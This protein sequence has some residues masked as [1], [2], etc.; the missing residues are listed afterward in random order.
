MD[1]NKLM[2]IKAKLIEPATTVSDEAKTNE[3][4]D[5]GKIID[6]N[7]SYDNYESRFAEL[8]ESYLHLPKEFKKAILALKDL[9]NT[10]YEFGLSVLLGMANTCCQHLYD[11][12]SYK[13]GIRPISLYIMVLLGTAGSKSTIYSEIRGPFVDYCKSKMDTLK[14]EDARYA[15]EMKVYKKLVQQYEKDVEAGL[16]PKYP[17]KPSPAETADYI[18]TKFTVNGLID[19][20]SSQPFASIITAEAGE[21]FSSHAFQGNK[22]DATRATEMTT[23]LTK[24]WDGDMISRVIK[25]ERV[26]VGNR[27]VNSLLMVQEGVI[28]DV[29][30]NKIFQEQGFTHRILI[31]QIHPF[32]KPDMSFDP[33]IIKKEQLARYGLKEYLDKL[34]NL[35]NIR[36]K[37]I[38]NKHFELQ[39]QIIESTDEAKNY[40]AKYFNSTKRWGDMGGKLELYSGFANRIHEHLIRIAATIAAFNNREQVIITLDEARAAVDIMNMFVDHRSKL[41]MGITDTRAD[42]TQG[43]KVMETYFKNNPNQAF[44]K[45]DLARKGPVGFRE[46]SDEQRK[47]IL[48]ELVSSEII[49]A[50]ENM[51]KNGKVIQ[52]FQYIGEVL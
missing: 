11:V 20:L 13:Y 43:A 49:V 37:F 8:P 24:L 47:N 21:F 22:Q 42:L 25:D 29:L 33:E 1:K 19:T 34:T 51:A 48:L 27:R 30:N 5:D 15:S 40:I 7:A 44:S 31:S 17:D 45:R 6:F 3:I 12:N 52:L 10:P 26:V 9:H 14:N 18:N 39:P 50:T 41:E 46:I 28:R 32:E 2:E 38:A 16:Q 4:K 36:P 23:S 35:L